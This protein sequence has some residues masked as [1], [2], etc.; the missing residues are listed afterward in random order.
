M[1]LNAMAFPTCIRDFNAILHKTLKITGESYCT[2]FCDLPET[3]LIQRK[4]LNTQ[5]TKEICQLCPP[6]NKK[7][8]T[9]GGALQLRLLKNGSSCK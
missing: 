5:T 2:E 7:K 3:W 8:K 1:K 6:P 9:Q 4:L